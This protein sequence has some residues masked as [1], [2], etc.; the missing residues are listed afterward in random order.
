MDRQLIKHIIA[1][2]IHLTPARQ[3]EACYSVDISDQDHEHVL[4]SLKCLDKEE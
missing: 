2:V 3:A 4:V 1:E